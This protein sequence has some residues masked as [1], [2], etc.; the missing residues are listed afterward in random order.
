MRAAAVALWAA[1]GDEEL[2]RGTIEGFTA[3]AVR[4]GLS[5]VGSPE[6]A[7]GSELVALFLA[8]GGV[9]AEVLRASSGARHS[10]LLHHGLANSF[11]AALEAAAAL[12]DLG[13]DVV[14]AELDGSEHMLNLM[15]RAMKTFEALR[16]LRAVRFGGP[17]RWLVHSAR[18]EDSIRA[19]LRVSVDEMGLE[20][21]VREAERVSQSEVE[22]E[23]RARG[24]GMATGLERALR[25]YIAMRRLSAGRPVTINCFE[26]VRAYGVTP[27]LALSLLNSDGVVAGCEGDLPSLMT[28]FMLSALSGR[29]AW[30]GN[31]MRGPEG[32]LAIVHCTFPMAEASAYELTSHYE[33]AAPL[34]VRAS[35]QVGRKATIAKYDPAK[36]LIRA[37][38]ATVL[39]GSQFT[40]HACR[41]Q[42]SFR[43]SD[44]ALRMTVKEPLGAHYAVVFDDVTYGLRVL[45][46]LLGLRY[47]E[48]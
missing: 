18:A 15:V 32:S 19:Q 6:E 4:A 2:V 45:A 43:V 21:L 46:A 13:V 38:G 35:V 12:R 48:A 26:L 1:S 28:M 39:R 20:E 42:V 10:L 29:P 9:E 8:T 40:P 33:T 14:V 44:E 3:M 22:G 25:V 16:G 37:I 24:L 17:A 34:A 31:I 23:A 7:S 41:T 30:M 11:P 47:E 27:C 36:N 5:L